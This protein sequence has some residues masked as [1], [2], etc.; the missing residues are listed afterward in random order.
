MKEQKIELGIN[1]GM[2]SFI[3]DP[4]ISVYLRECFDQF[5]DKFPNTLVHVH[6][7]KR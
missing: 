4:K 1:Y 6:L 3:R 7:L 2:D 5:E